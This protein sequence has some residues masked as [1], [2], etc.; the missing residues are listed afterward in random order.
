[1]RYD[2]LM[3]AKGYA[4]VYG[5][6]SFISWVFSSFSILDILSDMKFSSAEDGHLLRA[7]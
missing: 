5:H 4:F 1:M 3:R 2:D 7:R 6:L